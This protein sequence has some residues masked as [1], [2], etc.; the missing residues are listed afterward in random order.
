VNLEENCD[1]RRQ[2]LGSH[3]QTVDKEVPEIPLPIQ[4]LNPRNTSALFIV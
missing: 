4:K 2:R 3:R 1:R